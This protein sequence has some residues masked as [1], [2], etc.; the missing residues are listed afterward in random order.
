MK[1]GFM[2]LGRMGAGM[3]KRLIKGGFKPVIWNRTYQKTLEIAR[4][5]ADP[6]D[7]PAALLNKLP[8]HKIIWLMLPAG[9]V[10]EEMINYLSPHLTCGDILI[11]GANTHFKT[12]FQR[13]SKLKESGI[14]YIDVGVS[15]GVWGLKR[16]YC[17]MIGGDPETV[18]TL[19][20]VF[21]V[22][23]PGRGSLP[24]LM[25]PPLAESTAAEGY[26]HC[27]PPGSGH[28]V[29][30]IHNGIEYGIMQSYAEGLNMLNAASG[31]RDP[32]GDNF[33]FA[34]QEILELWRRGSVI[35]SW[36]MDLILSAVADDPILE[37]FDGFVQDSGEGR[38]MAETALEMGI[39]V[40]V[41]AVALFSRFSSRDKDVF[42]HKVLSAMRYQFGGHK[43]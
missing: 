36:L 30:M 41:L 11:D 16:G 20:P 32:G 28:F 35:G 23:A 2:G 24:V 10:T 4:F 33:N 43:E 14:H 21:Q 37:Q 8:D 38:W 13:Y 7:S 5:G 29:K 17:L 1:V 15:G 6:A 19:E 3:V 39:P 9:T 42:S 40:P 27:G 12:D 18:K 26:L 31:L 25:K 34:L 22:L